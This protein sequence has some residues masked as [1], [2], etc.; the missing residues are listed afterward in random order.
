MAAGY[1]DA[2]PVSLPFQGTESLSRHSSY[3]GAKHA[4]PRAGSQ[5]WRLFLLYREHG[6]QTDHQASTALNLPLATICARRCWLRDKG[7]VKAVDSVSGPFG[8]RNTS[9]GIR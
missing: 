2:E 4:L 5:A 8:T 9:W 7:L 1:L 6:P 3:E